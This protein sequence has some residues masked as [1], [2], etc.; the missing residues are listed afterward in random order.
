ME[1]QEWNKFLAERY[2]L[3]G[4][5]FWKHKQSGKWIISHKGCMV[6]ADKERI[7]FT[8]PE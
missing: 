1:N 6:I 7:E 8:K 3:E 5:H 2:A 4:H